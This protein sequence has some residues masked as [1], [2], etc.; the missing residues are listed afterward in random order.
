MK[1]AH[2]RVNWRAR[3]PDEPFSLESSDLARSF[4]N[5]VRRFDSSRGIPALGLGFAPKLP[6]M[7]QI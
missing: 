2:W 7:G 5:R 6:Q 4:L 1:I 3:R